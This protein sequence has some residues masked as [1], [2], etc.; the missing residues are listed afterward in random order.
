MSES[1]FTP[2]TTES[3]PVATL[4]AASKLPDAYPENQYIQKEKLQNEEFK[5]WKKTVPLLYETIHTYVL[6]APSL[7]VESLPGIELSSDKTVAAS[8]F[9]TG[10]YFGAQGG[11]NQTEFLK[12]NVIKLPST[13]TTDVVD[14]IPIEEGQ[15]DTSKCSETQKWSFTSEVNKARYN[16][17]T[18]QIATFMG[19]SG[20]I[21][22]LSRDSQIPLKTLSNHTKEGSAMEWSHDGK[23]LLTGAQDGLVCLWDVTKDS[24]LSETF[25]NHTSIVNDVAWNYGVPSLFGSVSDDTSVLF[26]D[27]RADP[28]S[29]IH[30]IMSAHTDSV[31][32]IDFNPS[33]QNNF[34]TGGA[35]NIINV[36]DLRNTTA[37]IRSLYGH[38]GGVT[39]LRFNPDDCTFLASSAN[40]KR[41]HIWDLT[42]IDQSYG[43]EDSVKDGSDDPALKFVHGGHAGRVLEFDWVKGV[44][45]TLISVSDDKLLEV[46]KPTLLIESIDED[47]EEEEEEDVEMKDV[48]EDKQVAEQEPTTETAEVKIDEAATKEE[49]R[50]LS[51]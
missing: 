13:L 38:H 12:L 7:T 29:P 5:I 8:S 36:W 26:H 24:P 11:A 25:F 40:D 21:N 1:R 42:K 30:S 15:A 45:S 39:Q 33:I 23:Y 47:E 17:L 10:T 32:A 51:N 16:P 3:T 19:G 14:S 27:Y 6:E 43:K 49:D 46:W 9:L 50:V 31:T 37:P 41:I 22:I 35:D 2:L 48:A 4:S 18:K 20:L 34:V 28:K 44:K